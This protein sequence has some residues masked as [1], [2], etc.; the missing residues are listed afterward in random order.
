MA[1]KAD[2]QKQATELGIELKHKDGKDL[3]I[4]E[5]ESAIDVQKQKNSK[6]SNFEDDEKFDKEGLDK[7]IEEESNEEEKQSGYPKYERP[8]KTIQAARILCIKRKGNNFS[9]ELEGDYADV[10]VDSEY[11]KKHSP[12][13]NGYFV[14]CDKGCKKYLSEKDFEEYNAIENEK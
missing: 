9:L 7:K 13:S 8:A 1:K 12:T 14:T 3:T 11:I 6:A 4:P 5:L 10:Q 2:L